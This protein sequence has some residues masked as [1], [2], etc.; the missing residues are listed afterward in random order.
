MHKIFVQNDM[1]TS[2][3]R[4]NSRTK[5]SSKNGVRVDTST[6]TVEGEK[7]YVKRSG[8]EVY[9]WLGIPFAEP[10]I[11]KLRL[12][13]T[14]PIKRWHNVK[15]T[16]E[17]PSSC[18]QMKDTSSGIWGIRMWNYNTKM[19]EDCLYLN[20]WSPIDYVN[21]RPVHP[22]KSK[23]KAVMVW[24][25]GG[26]YVAG[27]ATLGVYD[28]GMLS[29][30][31][32][33]IVVAI[34]YR[35]GFLGFGYMGTREIG[36]NQGLHDQITALTWLNNNIQFFGGDN[37]RITL[38]GESA[39]AA[40]ANYM[41][42]IK[43]AHS[44]FRNAIMQSASVLSNWAWLP[45]EESIRR[46]LRLGVVIGCWDEGKTLY[47]IDQVAA[48]N[49]LQRANVS[50]LVMATGDP[51][52]ASGIMQ[53][54]FAPVIDGD[55]ITDSPPNILN[56]D[57]SSVKDCPIIVGS[58]SHEANFWIFYFDTE[59]ASSI[60][61]YVNYDVRNPDYYGEPSAKHL[62]PLN[63]R[64]F[65]KAKLDKFVKYYPRF[66]QSRIPQVA[67]EAIYFNYYPY[68]FPKVNYTIQLDAV[69]SLVGDYHFTCPTLKLAEIFAKR[70]QRVYEYYFDHV[71]SASTWPNWMGTLHGDEIM[72]IFGEP[73]NGT[74][75]LYTRKE[76]QLSRRI[77][78]YWSNFAKSNNPDKEGDRVY[79]T[80]PEFNESKIY[81]HLTIDDD[82]DNEYLRRGRHKNRRTL[83]TD[84]DEFGP[85]PPIGY[86]L[87]ERNC[88]FWNAHLP[89]LISEYS[90]FHFPY[91]FLY[92]P[93][94]YNLRR[95]STAPIQLPVLSLILTTT[96]FTILLHQ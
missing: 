6:G 86:R 42:I 2:T 18:P 65:R 55:L 46:T 91:D 51:G 57:T 52:V 27:T 62:K 81:L 87:K 22:S 85:D 29:T 5:R 1:E 58:N 47:D 32:D 67:K 94:V 30:F 44:L 12:Q 73:F 88:R 70:G 59:M 13:R 10:P 89:Y 80:W 82:E 49:C 25:F 33:V 79:S 66:G 37:S 16:K 72:F 76:E 78:R 7:V 31:N 15:I 50:D 34:Q 26:G 63:D 23:K 93:K 96:L 20:I 61:N 21:G 83:R 71:S 77:M 11:G 24:I 64:I 75:N 48:L 69:D 3:L 38:F 54:P 92:R 43:K 28:G 39:G 68:G 90:K 41:M 8:K 36:G 17:Q 60:N 40:S 53:F 14:V 35:L 56:S 4:N 9:R 45:Q 84:S 74:E 19:S 95:Q